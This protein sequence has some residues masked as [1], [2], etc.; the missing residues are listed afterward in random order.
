MLKHTAKP[1]ATRFPDLGFSGGTLLATIPLF[2]LFYILLVLPFLPDDGTGRVE[3]MLFWP[4]AATITLLII[5]QNWSRVD[6]SFFRSIPIISLIA[7]L[8]FA[9]S[10]VTWAYS[11]EYAFSRVVVQILLC[12]VVVAPFALPIRTSHTIPTLHVCYAIALSISAA[13][14]LLFPPSPLGHAGF[15]THKQELGL[16]CAVGI[17]LSCHELLHRGWRRLL[18]MVMLLVG[19]WLIVESQSKSALALAIIAIVLSWL[20]VIAC[21]MS[22]FLSPAIIVGAIVLASVFVSNPIERIGYRLYGDATLTGRT[23]I[24]AFINYQISH[25]AWFGWGFHSYY[26]VPNSPHAAATGYIRNM[27]SSHSGYLE[28]KLETG[29][30][31]YWIFLVFIY[32]SLHSLVHLQRQDPVRAWGFLSIMLFAILINLLDSVWLGLNHV[33]VLY[34]IIVSQTVRSWSPSAELNKAYSAAQPD[35][36]LKQPSRRAGGAAHGHLVR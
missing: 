31:G 30:I 25:K 2:A 18:A 1:E 7:Y 27:P 5:F 23:G 15:F 3:N 32:S 36:R 17:L 22:R 14:V 35:R 13:Y 34:L 26:F 10:S 16:L 11:P 8:A 19:F 33:W 24:W 12:L 20:I 4:V 29:R 6:I 28:L 21:R 9:V